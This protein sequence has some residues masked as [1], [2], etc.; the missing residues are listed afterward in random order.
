MQIKTMAE[1]I[2]FYEYIFQKSLISPV[3][4]KINEKLVTSELTN[5]FTNIRALSIVSL[6][7]VLSVVH[8]DRCEFNQV[9][10]IISES[11]L[12]IIDF[13]WIL[14]ERLELKKCHNAY[15]RFV[16]A[17]TQLGSRGTINV[18]SF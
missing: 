14:C 17:V 16:G 15:S 9:I 18:I 1:K 3:K 12:T 4:F 13:H 5:Q 7:V 11:S 2:Y 10:S 6:C 8:L